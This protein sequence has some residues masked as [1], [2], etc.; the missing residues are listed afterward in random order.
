[1]R[2]LVAFFAL[3]LPTLL[4]TGLDAPSMLTVAVAAAAF[5]AL[6]LVATPVVAVALGTTGAAHPASRATSPLLAAR[7]TDPVH[8]P[9]RPR[10]PGPA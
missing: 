1:M 8:H 2:L 6:P 4:T 7:V 3:L 5:A 10:A 9:L